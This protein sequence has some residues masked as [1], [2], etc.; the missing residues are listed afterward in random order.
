[1]SGNVFE[2]A[3]FLF[4]LFL[5]RCNFFYLPVSQATTFPQYTFPDEQTPAT[6][7]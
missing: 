2:V 7:I 5:P 4:K 3:G 6:P 1:M